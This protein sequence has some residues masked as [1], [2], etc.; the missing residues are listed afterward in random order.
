[1]NRL[2]T[3]IKTEK[4][5]TDLNDIAKDFV[6]GKSGQGMLNVFVRHTTCAI[7]ILENEILLLADINNYLDKQFNNNHNYMHDKIEIRDVPIEER[8]NGH[9]HMKQLSF[10]TSEQIPVEDGELL[11]G[12]WQTIFLIEF[13]PI[14]D[15][16]IVL[17][18][19]AL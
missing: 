10:P 6:K 2:L 14:R 8:I 18:Y 1:M 12:T 19:T 4:Q 11:L 15:R 9:S 3:T 17:S 5:F 13:D 7:K 16:E